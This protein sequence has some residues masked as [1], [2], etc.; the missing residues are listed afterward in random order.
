MKLLLL[1]AVGLGVVWVAWSILMVV[2]QTAILYPGAR[3]RDPAP[4]PPAVPGLEVHRLRVGEAEVEAWLLPALDAP[5]PTP[6]VLFFHG[7]GEL[8]DDWPFAVEGL[9]RRGLAVL[10]VE[11]PG[12]GRSG[13]KPHQ[14]TLE[15][16][17]LRAWDLVEERPDLDETR[18]I[19]YGRSL[20]GGAACR[21]AALRP[22]AALA[23]SSTFTSVRALAARRLVPGFLVSQ[24]Y[25][26]LAVVRDFEGP[27]LI[28]HGRRDA[29]I[30]SEHGE[31][32]ARA[33]SHARLVLYDAH[34]NDCPPDLDEHWG[35]VAGLLAGVSGSAGE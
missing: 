29:T 26:N 31:A 25:D 16:A 34:H 18:V 32:L 21:L 14:S 19:A 35:D 27:I 7:N 11:F 23:L 3:F 12:Y 28:A 17:A 1:L 9:R 8:I 2:S 22:V 6:A 4:S 20:G 30:P 10:L 33:A 15:E 24:P 5:A 13:G